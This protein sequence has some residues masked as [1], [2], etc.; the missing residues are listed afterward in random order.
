MMSATLCINNSF[1]YIEKVLYT[2]QFEYHILKTDFD[3]SK[4]CLLYI[5]TG[6][7]DI[8]KNEQKHAIEVFLKDLLAI[9]KGRT[10]MLFTSFASIRDMA[11]SL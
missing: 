10:L 5:P 7:G 8:R 6:F 11:L 1:E 4:Q 3:Y 2:N 9:Y